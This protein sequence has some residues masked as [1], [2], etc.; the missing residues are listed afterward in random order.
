MDILQNSLTFKVVTYRLFL[1][2]L[3]LLISNLPLICKYFSVYFSQ[4]QLRTFLVPSI[5]AL[6]TA[7]SDREMEYYGCGPDNGRVVAYR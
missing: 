2:L 3:Q 6:P 5:L 4:I 1:W 7:K